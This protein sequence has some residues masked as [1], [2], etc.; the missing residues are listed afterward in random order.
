MKNVFYL[1]AALLFSL[2][3]FGGNN[4]FEGNLILTSY[5]NDTAAGKTILAV[6]ND[7]VA[8]DPGA[9]KKMVLNVNT[10]DFFTVLNQ[11]GQNMVAK[12]NVGVLSSLKEMP[13]FL[14]PF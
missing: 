12:L 3:A 6:R 5:K 11:G 13:A 2:Y 10:G 14:G 8:I 4:T 9:N 1:F 7:L